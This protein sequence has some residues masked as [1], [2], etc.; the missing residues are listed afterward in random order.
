M[1]RMTSHILWKIKFFFQTTNQSKIIRHSVRGCPWH[2]RWVIHPPRASC[3]SFTAWPSELRRSRGITERMYLRSAGFSW[4]FR[5][6]NLQVSTCWT[7]KIYEDIIW[8][9][10]SD[11]RW[12]S[13]KIM[14]WVQVDQFDSLK[15]FP[16]PASAAL[17]KSSHWPVAMRTRRPW[18]GCQSSPSL[19]A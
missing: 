12:Y 10:W 5:V 3:D 6:K 1:E 15:M 18:T 19:D 8:R 7:L 17:P 4:D 13:M 2:T 11:F 14:K 9:L 16:K